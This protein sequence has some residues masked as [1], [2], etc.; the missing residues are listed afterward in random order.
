MVKCGNNN[1]CHI[2]IGLSSDINKVV[3]KKVSVHC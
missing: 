3:S 1:N 2:W